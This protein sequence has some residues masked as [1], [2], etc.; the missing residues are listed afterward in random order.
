MAAAQPALAAQDR[1]DLALVPYYTVVGEWF[2]SLHIVNTSSRTQVAK[3][4]FRRATGAMV[5]LDF[6]LV[7]SPHDVYAGFLS[8]DA[9]GAI[10]CASPDTS[11]TVP[12][13]QGKRLE[14]QA[15]YRAGAESGYVEIIAMG[16]PADER[17]PIAR[18][19]RR[20]RSASRSTSAGAST[21]DSTSV[22]TAAM[23]LDCAAV[24]SNFFAD[25]AGTGT[26]STRL[27]AEN[28][29]IT[30]QARSSADA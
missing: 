9:P 2:T 8:R 22:S 1:G 11:C 18:A 6:N 30:W 23:P 21:S 17:Q 24:R 20:V 25:G 28:H 12:A 15:I 13:T 16:A 29:A 7:L 27:G 19:A 3:V 5:A 4:R 10:V 14:M 26:R